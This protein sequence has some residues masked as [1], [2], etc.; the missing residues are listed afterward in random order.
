MEVFA[1]WQNNRLQDSRLRVRGLDFVLP[2]VVQ[3]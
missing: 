3:P 1:V 2:Y